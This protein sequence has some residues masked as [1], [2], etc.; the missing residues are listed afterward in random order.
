MSCQT[1]L[2]SCMLVGQEPAPSKC[3]LMSTSAVVRR[4]MK[5]WVISDQG[6]HW[7]VKLDVRDLGG[8]LDTTYI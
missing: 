8:H 3:I 2:L 1:F 4:D 5:D 7:S 6:E